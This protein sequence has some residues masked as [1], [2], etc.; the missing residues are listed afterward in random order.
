MKKFDLDK[1]VFGLE[2]LR[3]A[4]NMNWAD[5]SEETGLSTS[6]VNRLHRGGRPDADS[7]AALL[8]WS[9]MDMKDLII[10]APLEAEETVVQTRL[11][12]FD[13]ADPHDR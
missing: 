2:V 6:T 7:L 8:H 1:F 3:K 11:V 12:G 10:D 13:G 5:I 4:R 9:K